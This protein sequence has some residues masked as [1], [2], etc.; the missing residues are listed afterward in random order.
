MKSLKPFVMKYN[1]AHSDLDE[2][3]DS[4]YRIAIC[5]TTFN[6]TK[7]SAVPSLF[8]KEGVREICCILLYLF[9]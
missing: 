4:E 8:G 2:E 3:N 9:R 5:F 1:P 6:M 7:T